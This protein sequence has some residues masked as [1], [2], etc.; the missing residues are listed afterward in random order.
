MEKLERLILIGGL[1]AG[2]YYIYT[3]MNEKHTRNDMTF[4][5]K[6]GADLEGTWTRGTSDA[7][8]K[9]RD[10]SWA[11]ESD[12]AATYGDLTLSRTEQQIFDFVYF[13]YKTGSGDAAAKLTFQKDWDKAQGYI[14]VNEASKF[15]KIW[16][17]ITQNANKNPPID[18]N[19]P[20][21][22]EDMFGGGFGGGQ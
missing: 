5:N 7:I 18:T 15:E 2:G 3:K 1:A 6:T 4:E 12:V 8:A 13:P 22:M 9:F 20:G 11:R 10:G 14:G 17:W 19:D 16:N 21:W